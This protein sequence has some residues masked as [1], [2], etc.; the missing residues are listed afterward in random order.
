MMKGLKGAGAAMLG[1]VIMMATVFGTTIG[2]A[3]WIYGIF[4]E[5]KSAIEKMREIGVALIAL[6]VVLGSLNLT[7]Q[8][9]QV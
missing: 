5:S 8:L 2:I 7:E 6:G 1:G 3:L 9:P 4:A